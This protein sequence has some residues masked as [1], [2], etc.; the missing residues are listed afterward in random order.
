MQVE[1][2]FTERFGCFGVGTHFFHETA[3]SFGGLAVFS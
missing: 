3:K 2:V 1:V